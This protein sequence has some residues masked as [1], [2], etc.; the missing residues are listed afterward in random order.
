MTLAILI[1]SAIGGAGGMAA[2][3]RYNSRVRSMVSPAARAQGGGG[4]PRPEGPK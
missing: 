4:G 3:V 2:A 1:L